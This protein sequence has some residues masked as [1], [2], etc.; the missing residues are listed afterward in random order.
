MSE[1]Y[2]YLYLNKSDKDYYAYYYI[3]G[4]TIDRYKDPLD[5]EKPY[6]LKL[7]NKLNEAIFGFDK[8][9]QIEDWVVKIK[10]LLKE[11]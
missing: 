6:H 4:V 8:D 3:K 11:K 7:K 5:K 2:I 9:E 1:N 10:A